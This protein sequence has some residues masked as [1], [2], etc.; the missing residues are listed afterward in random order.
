MRIV[1]RV[2]LRLGDITSNL[3][4]PGRIPV[5]LAV[6]A[7]VS[8]SIFAAQKEPSA[9]SELFTVTNVYTAHFHFTADQWEAM[10]PEQSAAFD[11]GRPRGPGG[12]GG[13]PGRGGPGG[14]PRFGPGMFMAPVFMNA[15]DTDRDGKLTREEFSSLGERWFTAF[16]KQKT[17][18]LKGDQLRDGLN[19]SLGGGGPRIMLQGREGQRN[20]LASA[21]GIEFDYVKANLE[22]AGRNFTNVAVRYKGNGTWM[23]SQGS[24]KR[25]LKVDL[26]KNVKGQKIA[27]ISKLNFHNCVTDGAWMNE[28]LSHQ[29]YRDIGVAAPRT[30]YAR[31]YV[32]VPGKHDKTYLGLYSLVENIDNNFAD[33]RF[34]TKKGA[35]F[36]PVTPQLFTFLGDDWNKYKQT[37]D[38]KDDPAMSDC[39]R[40][41][42]FARLVTSGSDDE[43]AARA[44]EFLD[45]EQFAK[46]MAGTVWLATLDSILSVGQ[47]YYLYLEPKTRKF[48]FFPWDLDHSFGHFFLMGSQEQRNELSL[49]KPWRGE[50][51]FLERVFK[52]DAFKKPYLARLKQ[53]NETIGRPERIITQVDTVAAAIRPAI[54]AESEEKLDRFN[55]LV[56]GESAEPPSF[57]GGPGPGGRGRGPGGPP[58]FGQVQPI[59]KFVVARHKSVTDQLTGAAQG[60]D[61]D[62]PP[63]GMPNFGPGSF[64]APAI[65]GKFDADNNNELSRAEFTEGFKSWFARWDAAKAGEITEEKL[66]DAL[67]SEFMPP[68]APGGPGGGRPPE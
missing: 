35:I 7:F 53:I 39:Q 65:Q 3:I 48:Q 32:T 13:P 57:G 36:K 29:F 24:L 28:V 61:L 62:V 38:P 67:D 4:V 68:G 46:Y 44:P 59:K 30:A 40:V 45:L 52:L 25:S 12:P 33:E 5:S 37:Y 47:N 49:E 9:P 14:A 17:G 15:A 58:G 31:V 66:R 10:E 18:V 41:I 21:M 16:D 2:K 54:E 63:P 22:F 64:L 42:D 8:V 55:K 43:F 26:N 20:G 6:L 11:G 60:A 34:G 51:R 27:G 50:N 19:A 1:K 56:A 23:Q